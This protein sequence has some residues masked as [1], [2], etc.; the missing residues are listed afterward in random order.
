MKCKQL[1]ILSLSLRGLAASPLPC[2]IIFPL[3]VNGRCT[4][5]M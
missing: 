5:Y 3:T 2:C 1:H 4:S